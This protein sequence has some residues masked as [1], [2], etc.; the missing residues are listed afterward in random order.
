[1]DTRV[2]KQRPTPAQV[3]DDLPWKWNTQGAVFIVG[4]L[5][6]MFDAWDVALGGLLI[7]LLA[8]EWDVPLGT[9][10]FA[11]TAN[12]I[13]MAVGAVLWGGIADRLGRRTAFSIT[14]L[15]F[16]LFTAAGAFSPNLET[17][18][19]LRFIAGIGL[20]G[21][22]PVDYALVAEF[23]PARHRGRVLTAMDGW[24]PIGATGAAVT[25]AWI[26]SFGS[27]RTM[28]LLMAAPVILLFFVRLFVP[29]SPLHLAAAGKHAEADA[30]LRRLIKR[31]GAQI[32]AW[33]HPQPTAQAAAVH[34]SRTLRSRI[35]SALGQ[36]NH[37]WKHSARLTASTWAV[38][39]GVLLLYYAA[40]TWLP[41]VLREQGQTDQAA[42]L[43]TGAMTGAGLLGVVTAALVIDYVGR[44]L[45]LTLSGFSSAVLLA[46][47]AIELTSHPGELTTAAKLAIVS[48]G[49]T[50]QTAVPALYTYGSEAYPT[51]LRASGFGWAS[52]VSRIATGIAPFVYGAWL[53]PS[54]GLTGTFG[55]TG[56]LT[57][58][59]LVLMLV[60]GR[61]D[62]ELVR[63]D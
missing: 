48:F 53:L 40:L 20:G 50:I 2:T 18:L 61:E 57:V 36:L 39:I 11:A 17:F 26:L 24:W 21:A 38:F 34:T 63:T 31:T 14:L 44:R 32:D 22:I 52:S 10:A 7:P 33:Q 56:A 49:F 35:S 54:I 13:G 30:V 51:Q 16:S 19:V 9:A 28:M 4:G 55:A 46:L 45:L 59:G 1:M 27:W 25:S 62:R 60:W 43:V 42:F 5:G 47:F 15:I 12:L 8:A 3:I 29:E 41:K 58:I 23:T 37:L 6:F